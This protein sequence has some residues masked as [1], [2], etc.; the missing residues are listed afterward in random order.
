MDEF[1]SLNIQPSQSSRKKKKILLVILVILLFRA[2]TFFGDD[3]SKLS[4][5]QCLL[6]QEGVPFTN[7]LIITKTRGGLVEPT[8]NA[9]SFF[10][11]CENVFRFHFNIFQGLSLKL[12]IDSVISRGDIT[13][14]FYSCT[15]D[16][17]DVKMQEIV[18]LY[19][20]QAVYSLRCHAKCR[21]FME[22]YVLKTKKIK[23]TKSPEEN[24]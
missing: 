14:M 15:Y 4:V 23:K 2:K 6:K 20:L 3:A 16:G 13:D 11:S 22:K 21:Q 17:N 8:D 18:L 1:L 7:K 19:I 12:F 9:I 5:V 10:V 24:R